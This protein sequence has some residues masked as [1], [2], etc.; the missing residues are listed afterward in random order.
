MRLSKARKQIV[1]AMMR[2]TI[3]EAAGSVL[4]EHG[5]GGVTMDRV[6]TMAGLAKG[7]LYN[8]F[9]D[10]DELMQFVQTR[11]IEPFLQKIRAIAEEQAPARDKLKK[12]LLASLSGTI[13]HQNMIRLLAQSEKESE[14]R[15]TI[16]PEMLKILTDIFEQGIRDGDF[17]PH[18]T[19]F[20]AR[21]FLG[22]LAELYEMQADGT[23]HEELNEYADA[24]ID[25]VTHGFSIHVRKDESTIL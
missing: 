18:R 16:R 23:T 14:V 9:H 2:D 13:E 10:K 21:M 24:L 5:V 1:T 3:F 15:K 12:V 8:Y 19:V 4:Q 17:R 6:A 25:T 20:T 11:L 7:S 22:A